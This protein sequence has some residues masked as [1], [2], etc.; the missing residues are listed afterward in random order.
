MS[1]SADGKGRTLWQIL[2]GSNKKDM[3]PLE[4]KYHNPL[5]A[6]V[7]MNI[8]FSHESDWQGVNFVIEQIDVYQ[9]EI[10]QKKFYHTDYVL[11]GVSLKEDQPI[12]VRLRL[13]PD[14]NSFNKLGCKV[15]VLKM[16]DGFSWDEGFYNEVLC[17]ESDE[18]VIN[19]G[20]DNDEA[21]YARVDG[22]H[23]PYFATVT[24]LIDTDGD[25]TVEDEEL[26]HYNTEYW[27]YQRTVL[28]EYSDESQEYLWVE[29]DDNTGYF[30]LYLGGEV[31]PDQIMI[32]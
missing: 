6:K 23:D 19:N 26:E 18:F 5:Q 13:E 11:K 21:R 2:T 7:G 10:G 12:R 25:G 27:D 1:E 22:V 4:L 9:T 28:G 14:D 31:N 3:K 29:K 16:I 17:H 24:V 32:L 30:S 15:Q 20:D 8:T